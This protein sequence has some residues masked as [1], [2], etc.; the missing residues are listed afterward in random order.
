[1]KVPLLILVLM[2]TGCGNKGHHCK[3][4]PGSGWYFVTQTSPHFVGRGWSAE[5]LVSMGW[6]CRPN[7]RAWCCKQSTKVAP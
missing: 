5:A 6:E 2:L 3:H 7:G 4:M 1:M